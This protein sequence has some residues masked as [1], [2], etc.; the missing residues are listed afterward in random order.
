[1]FLRIVVILF[2]LDLQIKYDDLKDEKKKE[3]TSLFWGG[4][5]NLKEKQKKE[6]LKTMLL[7]KKQATNK[8]VFSLTLF[9][10]YSVWWWLTDTD[11]SFYLLPLADQETS[12]G[13]FE[14]KEL[15]IGLVNNL[16][17]KVIPKHKDAQVSHS[18]LDSCNG[19]WVLLKFVAIEFLTLIGG[20]DAKLLNSVGSRWAG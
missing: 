6:R 3:K 15:M 2:L 5:R 9:S 13:G 20:F 10:R 4:S 16:I 12:I 17:L 11:V 19:S 7:T 14:L 1:M 18:L 8:T